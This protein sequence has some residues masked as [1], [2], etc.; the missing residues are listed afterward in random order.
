MSQFFPGFPDKFHPCKECVFA[1][2]II[3]ICQKKILL[4]WSGLFIPQTNAV[5]SLLSGETGWFH[6]SDAVVR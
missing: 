5:E 4:P 6:M 2:L 1:G 3:R